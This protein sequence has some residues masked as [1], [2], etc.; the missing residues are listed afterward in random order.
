MTRLLILGSNQLGQAGSNSYR[1]TYRGS[2]DYQ[3]QYAPTH[4]AN[5]AF[6]R[7]CELGGQT[8]VLR[9]LSF[10]LKLVAIYRSLTPP[11]DFDIVEVVHPDEAPEFSADL[12]GYDVSSGGTGCSMLCWGLDFSRHLSN[13]TS[14][15][16]PLIRLIEEAFRPRLN[17]NGLFNNPRD[18][19]YCLDCMLAINRLVPSF[20]E[21]DL[22]RYIVS[23]LYLVPS[24]RLTQPTSR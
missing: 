17:S 24:E 4:P 7:F 12:L 6:A 23:G 3:T 9:D 18:A 1:G 22:E 8:L 15:I 19:Q 13:T 5:L 21:S 20:F 16:N 10:A 11:Q 2:P 14:G